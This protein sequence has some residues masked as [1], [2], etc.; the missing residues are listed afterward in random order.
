MVHFCKALLAQQVP[1]LVVAV[2][3]PGW[4]FFQTVH[5]VPHQLGHLLEQH[6]R[7]Q[8][9]KALCPIKLGGRSRQHASASTTGWEAQEAAGALVGAGSSSTAG[10]GRYRATAAC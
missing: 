1:V 7:R 10:Q 4:K 2:S 3:Y 6:L 9:G 8:G 5:L